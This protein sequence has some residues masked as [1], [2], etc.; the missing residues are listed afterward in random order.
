MKLSAAVGG[1][2]SPLNGT[3]RMRVNVSLPYSM[4]P[5]AWQT[6]VMPRSVRVRRSFFMMILVQLWLPNNCDFK[7]AGVLSLRCSL[8]SQARRP[9]SILMG[10]SPF[11]MEIKFASKE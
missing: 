8:D 6:T 2:V 10:L 4:M 3:T 7:F 9:C 11:P 1:K 5:W